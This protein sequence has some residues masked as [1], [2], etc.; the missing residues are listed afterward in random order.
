MNYRHGFH[1]GNH[2]DCLKHALL[3]ALLSALARKDAPFAVI[4]LHAGRGT[5]DLE[6]SEARRTGEWK[7]GI[8]RL[9]EDTPAPLLPFVTLVRGL[10]LYPGSPAIARAMLRAGDRLFANEKHPEEAAALAEW[11]RGEGRVS[12][13]QGDAYALK[14]LVPPP[15]SRRGLVLFDPPY[16]AEDEWQKLIA[17]LRA[18]HKAAPTLMLA[19]WYPVKH[20]APVR[21]F[22]D[23]VAEAGL[24]RR[25][26]AALYLRPPLDPERLN[27]S[28]VMVINAPYRFEEEARPILDALQHRL[29]DPGAGTVHL[30]AKP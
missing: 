7:A 27:G 13:R 10:G 9:L 19:A 23:A 29:A 22:R 17:G 16:E 5:Y 3:I 21:A 24:P 15:G 30:E 14:G 25:V 26:D 28:G 20:L 12:V 4:D 8:G 18:A 2:G 11:A 1:A 6:A